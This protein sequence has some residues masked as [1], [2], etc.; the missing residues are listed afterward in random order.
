[1][2]KETVRVNFTTSKSI[3]KSLE[4]LADEKGIS[5]S[6]QISVALYEWFECRKNKVLDE[7]V[8]NELTLE[9]ELLEVLKK[10]T[11]LKFNEE[12][13]LAFELEEEELWR[14]SLLQLIIKYESSKDVTID[15]RKE[16]YDLLCIDNFSLQ[17]SSWYDKVLELLFK[18][19][20]DHIQDKDLQDIR[21]IMDEYKKKQQAKNEESI[22]K[23]IASGH[24]VELLQDNSKTN[25]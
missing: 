19:K 16:L 2:K 8:H 14:R 3:K 15:L 13:D 10:Y 22:N 23:L 18:Y 11:S 25:L 21:N 1:M 4:S 6:A 9:E 17:F 20:S 24:M 12:E 5:L 7:L